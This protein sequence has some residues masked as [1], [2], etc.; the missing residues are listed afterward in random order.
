MVAFQEILPSAVGFLLFDE[1]SA[2]SRV[3]ESP[4]QPAIYLLGGNRISDAYGM[5]G[6]V[7][8]NGSAAGILTSGVTGLV[9]LLAR[10]IRLGANAERYIKDRNYDGYIPESQ[11][12]LK[13]FGDK[14]RLPVDLA[15]E[16]GGQRKELPVSALPVD[17]D[18]FDIGEQTIAAYEREIA[19]A[20]TVFLNGPAGVYET[21]A[22]E[23]GTRRLFEA[24]QN[25]SAYT[26]IGGGD[27]VTAA[28]KYIDAKRISH[29]C[30]AG[31]AMVQYL[32][33][34]EM[35]LMKAMKKAAQKA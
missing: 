32:S 35:P 6:Q 27:S 4:E 11:R 1:V 12:L 34:E 17:Q 2:L 31:G 26:V 10:G 20:G 9:M 14:I 13:E 3:L 19:S 18:L 21:P 25:S 24:M 5:M 8:A 33:G 23:K 30:T 22:F 29:I 16:E 7:L 28:A 15:V